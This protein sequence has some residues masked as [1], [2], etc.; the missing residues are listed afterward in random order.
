VAGVGV[1]RGRGGWGGG[2]RVGGGGGEERVD[3]SQMDVAARVYREKGRRRSGS[4]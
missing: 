1:A 2:G 4:R 3:G